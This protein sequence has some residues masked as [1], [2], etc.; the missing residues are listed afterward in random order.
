[1]KRYALLFFVA[2]AWGGSAA[3]AAEEFVR[4]LSLSDITQRALEQNFD[5]QAY[6]YDAY[7]RRT[8]AG[9][10]E[11]IFDTFLSA[12]LG[13]VSDEKEK[14]SAIAGTSAMQRQ[15]SG[16]LE[17]LLPSGTA[18]AVDFADIRTTSNSAF[19]AFSPSYE[20]SLKLSVR[21]A[22]G[23]NF[24]GRL[25]RGKIKI[26]RLQIEQS[27]L[28]LLARVENALAQTQLTYWKVSL[29]FRQWEVEK[30]LFAKAQELLR[31]FEE[32]LRLGLVEAAEVDAVAANT[33]RR[34]AEVIAAYQ[35]LLEITNELLFALQDESADP[36]VIP[37]ELPLP[38]ER[39]PVFVDSLRRAQECRRDY[40]SAMR[41]VEEKKLNLAMRSREGWPRIDVEASFL[42]N[43]LDRQSSE[44]WQAVRKEDNTELF[45]GVSVR[46]PWENSAAESGSERAK[47]EKAKALLN[48]KR[49]EFRIYRD[50]HSAV[51]AVSSSRKIAALRKQAWELET[52]KLAFEE[53]RF[54][55]GRSNSDVL[56][57][58][59]Q[60]VAQARLSYA[61][62]LF[63]YQ[64]NVIGLKLAEQ[65]LLAEYWQGPL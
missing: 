57:R 61:A 8:D 15:L 13:Y 59:Q 38:P 11:S 5:I 26:T 60:D 16:G 24:F 32:K 1:M 36:R 14:L 4:R 41:A 51:H 55:S 33:A 3:C 6:K 29:A 47:Q 10:A 63:E 23:D 40:L 52:Q 48:V 46:I 45:A 35:R 28:S 18:V 7:I 12:R 22:L 19:S 9:S 64:Q 20:G 17:K 42:R 62:A 50:V 31:A 30:D 54:A 37:D 39:D 34:Q 43:G 21:Q 25:D 2:I 27:D 44:A 56:I 49:A 53:Q 58:Y 65:S